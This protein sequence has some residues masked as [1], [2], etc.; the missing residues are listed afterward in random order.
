VAVVTG[1]AS[2]IGRAI[3]YGCAEEGMKVVL[4]DINKEGLT[5]AV[6][7]L[8]ARAHALP[9]YIKVKYISEL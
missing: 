6:D 7:E 8:E 1:A 9:R 4:A 2:G 3:A 5:S